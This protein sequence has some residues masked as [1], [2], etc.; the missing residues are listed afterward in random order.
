MFAEKG[1]RKKK[2]RKHNGRIQKNQISGVALFTKSLVRVRTKERLSRISRAGV[3]RGNPRQSLVGHSR[4]FWTCSPAAA[5]IGSV[6][7]P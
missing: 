1:G 6:F 2:K 4:W 3:V 7:R 5:A